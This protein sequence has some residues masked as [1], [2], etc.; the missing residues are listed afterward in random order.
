MNSGIVVKVWNIK[1]QSIAKGTKEQLADS[2]GYILNDEK[3]VVHTEL[4][5][6]DQLTREC[7]YVENDLKTFDGAYVGGHNVT[8]TNV[9]LAVNEMMNVKKFFDKQD[10][11]AALHMLI[12]L[13]EEE[14]DSVNASKL[15]QL[16]S[17]VLKDI[18]PNNQAVFAVHTNTDNLH[19]HVIV[20]S[21]G[22]NGRKIH[23]DS[24]FVSKVLQPCINKYAKWYNFTPNSKWEK[25]EKVS[26]YKY[27]QLK[28]VLRNAIDVAIENADSF[29]DFVQ[30]LNE[31]GID[32]RIGK[33]ISLCIPGQRKAIRTHNLGSNY[34]R[35]A[36]IEKII[37][38]REKFVLTDVGNYTHSGPENIFTPT[39]VKMKKYKD[40]TDAE[41]KQ[42][43]RELKL[44]KNP[45]RENRNMSWQL[46]KIADD[47]N[48]FE[49]VQGYVELYSDDGSI[50]GA[51]DAILDAKK[52]VAHDKNMI[53]YAMRKY[54][55]ILKIYEEMKRLERKSYLYEYQN[56]A[57]YRGEFE[58]YRE[59]TRRLKNNYGKEIFEVADFMNECTERTLYARAQLNVLSQQ[60]RELKKYGLERGM[61]IDDRDNFQNVIGYEWKADHSVAI[62]MNSFYVAAI[63]SDVVLKVTKSVGQDSDGKNYQAYSIAVIDTKGNIIDEINNHKDKEH[64]YDSMKKFQKRYGLTACK[65]FDQY[66][67]ARE[68]SKQTVDLE[69]TQ[70]RTIGTDLKNM[71]EKYPDLNTK[72]SFPQAVNHVYEDRPLCVIADAKT[73]SYIA[74]SSIKDDQLEIEVINKF[75]QYQEK[76]LVP[77]VKNK[78][79]YGYFHIV[80]LQ[81][82]YGFSDQVYEFE[83]VESAKK[84]ITDTLW[85]KSNVQKKG[86]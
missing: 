74:L 39:V 82:K 64:F 85:T 23:Q 84:Y 49:R 45:W 56:V 48:S 15:M 35:D 20:N 9:A 70:S 25:K 28:A 7:K 78:D 29:D 42:I 18:F 6:L 1:G 55:P 71:E 2:V 40:M 68:Y 86:L 22:L 72:V 77:L 65:K 27:P 24:N 73:P 5:S 80:D 58:R 66:Y 17:D 13:P 10:G 46:N 76:I 81:K 69:E 47:L 75:G 16:C 51:L 38:K 4:N 26:S 63:N 3:T 19:V 41:K 36:I 57:E 62:E 31:Q 59:L 21:V 43:I 83:T 34:T 60:Y 79:S 52:R 67:V 50:Q 54:H 30:N 8:S 44:G 37:T 32:T 61:F 33:H 14:S 11:R 53:A 12:S